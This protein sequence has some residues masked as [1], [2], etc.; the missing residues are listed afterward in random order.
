MNNWKNSSNLPIRAKI[1]TSFVDRFD[2]EIYFVRGWKGLVLIIPQT[3]PF[4]RFFS[5]RKTQRTPLGDKVNLAPRF[6][7]RLASPFIGQLAGKGGPRRNK[8]RATSV[9][10]R[11]RWKGKRPTD[12][13]LHPV[14]LIQSGSRR[15]SFVIL[16]K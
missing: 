16:W 15:S 11:P 6:P 12:T 3:L 7:R 5:P 9:P 1:Y 8:F 2:E 13:A 10:P 14:K 4:F